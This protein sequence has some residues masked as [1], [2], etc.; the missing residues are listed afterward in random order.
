M[1][2]DDTRDRTL[3]RWVTQQHIPKG[4]PQRINVRPDIDGL[5]FQLLRTGEM[6]GTNE[7]SGRNRQRFVYRRNQRLC[8]AEIDDL[9]QEMIAVILVDQHNIRR[10]DVSMDQF[11][12]VCSDQSARHLAGNSQREL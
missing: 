12:A 6:W 4:R 7:S 9:Y 8:E 5:F 11:L 3:K 10:L 1:L 2:M